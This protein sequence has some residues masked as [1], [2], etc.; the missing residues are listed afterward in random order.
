VVYKRRHIQEHESGG[1]FGRG[2]SGRARRER[3]RTSRKREGV[4][5]PMMLRKFSIGTRIF[6]VLLA[7]VLFIVAVVGAFLSMR[8]Q[9]AI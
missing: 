9:S 8:E 6:L 7:M 1:C 3:G 4:R 2:L 5:R